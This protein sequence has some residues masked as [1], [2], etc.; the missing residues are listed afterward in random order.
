MGKLWKAIRNTI[1]G[2]RDEA[3]AKLSDPVRDGKFAIEDSEKEIAQF[4]QA[5]SMMIAAT[6]QI[7][8]RRDEAK[9]NKAKYDKIAKAIA[10]KIE[11]G[12]AGND[13]MEH[14][15][16]AANKV[17]EFDGIM[18]GHEAEIK[19]NKVSEAQLRKQLDTAQ[20]KVQRAKQQI[21]VRA[22]QL[23]SAQMRKKL[24][25]SAAGLGQGEGLSALDDL[26]RAVQEETAE[27]DAMDELSA[28][29]DEHLEELY[30]AGSGVSQS[31]A[32]AKYLKK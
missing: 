21:H 9:A 13:A 25:A 12:E 28:S 5:L 30:G 26:D 22:A 14:L 2:H 24:N 31:E 27:A 11:S 23:Q 7:E 6:K 32:A 10:A 19:K 17:E 16:Q 20:N 18:K 4:R 15:T 29:P 1:R 3:A 8:Q